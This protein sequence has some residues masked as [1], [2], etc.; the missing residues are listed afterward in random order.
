M[1][2]PTLKLE[3]F[4]ENKWTSSSIRAVKKT[5][6]DIYTAQYAPANSEAL[7]TYE[8]EKNPLLE[9]LYKKRKVDNRNE[10]DRYLNSPVI[11]IETN[12]TICDRLLWWKVCRIDLPSI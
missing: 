8:E 2:D 1:L 12:G 9:H 11:P 10:L 5:V 6:V 4:K 3:F 7:T